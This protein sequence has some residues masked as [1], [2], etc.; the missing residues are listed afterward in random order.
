MNEN[1][2]PYGLLHH[3]HMPEMAETIARLGGRSAEGLVFT[4]HLVPMTR[5]I[6]VTIYARGQA[7]TEECQDAA[8]AFYADR[9]LVRVTGRPPQTKWASG[10]TLAFVHY[11]AD[12]ARNLVMALGVVDNLGKGAAGHAIQNANLMLGLPTSTGLAGMPIWP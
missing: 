12:P 11:A 7:T 4:P 3:T 2:V 5:G 10:S 9:P 1:F 8:H 6:L